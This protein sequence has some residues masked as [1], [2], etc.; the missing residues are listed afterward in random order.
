MKKGFT[1]IELLV[2]VLIIGV[3]SAIAL[4]QYQ[5]AVNRSRGAEALTT[6]RAL[7]D[8]ANLYYLENGTYEG[9]AYTDTNA[10]EKLSIAVPQLKNFKYHHDSHGN[11][12][13]SF[14]GFSSATQNGARIALTPNNDTS[15]DMMVDVWKGQIQKFLCSSP[16]GTACKEFFPG[17]TTPIGGAVGCLSCNYL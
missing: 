9:L 13:N 11:P 6:L 3:L 14:E 8:A 16:Q 4:P 2:V 12:S 1:L 17:C 7:A 10:A 15:I 5:K